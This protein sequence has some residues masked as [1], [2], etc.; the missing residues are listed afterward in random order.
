M[1]P[2]NIEF[3]LDIFRH[4]L[5]ITGFV[6]S[7]L[8]LLDYFNVVSGGDI[9]K[10]LRGKKLTQYICSAF[11]GV[12]PGCLGTFLGVSLYMRG[13]LSMGAL[14]AAFIASAG[15]G[16]FVMLALFPRKALLLFAGLFFSGIF[17]G[18]LLDKM[19]EKIKLKPC[20][21]CKSVMLHKED[22]KFR[23]SISG[24]VNSWRKLSFIR[25]ALTLL[26]LGILAVILP[27]WRSWEWEKVTLLILALFSLLIVATSSDHYLEEH[28]WVHIFKKHIWRIFLWTFA[29]LVLTEGITGQTDFQT[30]VG[31]NLY[32]VLLASALIGIIP[33]SGPHLVFVTLF[34]RGVIPFSILLTNSIIQEGHGALPLLAYTTR[35]TIIIKTFKFVVGISL[36]LILLRSGL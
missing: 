30:L 2:A 1:D 16:A 10:L 6:F 27:E 19:A 36:G 17:F 9:A 15:D 5:L 22:R 34:A 12:M 11:L 18:W 35:D 24:V 28:I 31:G 20:R 29:A 4:A 33:D 21:D 7:M 8:L 14:T 3:F 13:L 23:L 26:L 25:F 32:F